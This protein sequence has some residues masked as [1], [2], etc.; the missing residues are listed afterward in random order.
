MKNDLNETNYEPKDTKMTH[1][2]KIDAKLL[3]T[4]LKETKS[5]KSEHSFTAVVCLFQ[6]AGYM[7]NMGGQ[8]CAQE[9]VFS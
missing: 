3:Q 1:L 5:S 2:P 6:S 8:F 9:P 4:N 7:R